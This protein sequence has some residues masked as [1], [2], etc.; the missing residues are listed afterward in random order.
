[1]DFLDAIFSNIFVIIAILAAI[2]GLF[3]RNKNED[4]GP[5]IFREER[6]E[7]TNYES[8][9]P[10][11]REEKKY[12]NYETNYETNQES[13]MAIDQSNSWYAELEQSRQRLEKSKNEIKLKKNDVIKRKS[14]YPNDKDS[15]SLSIR[16]TH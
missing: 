9:S 14:I 5:P 15:S 10:I 2:S 11:D 13:Q 12:D 4:D 16:N 6:S 8:S 3:G 7:P 1:M